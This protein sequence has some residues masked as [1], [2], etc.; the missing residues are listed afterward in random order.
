MPHV[1]TAQVDQ[2]VT[3]IKT[4]ETVTVDSREELATARPVIE[5]SNQ[6][7]ILVGSADTK[8]LLTNVSSALAAAQLS[9]EEVTA[10]KVEEGS[11]VRLRVNDHARALKI[12]NQTWDIGRNYGQSQ[13]FGTEAAADILSQVEYQAVSGDALLV[14]LEDKPG[15]LASIMKR[16]RD[17]NI[18][19]RSVRLLWRGKYKAVVELA[20]P[21]PV[22][23]KSL[24]TDQVF[25]H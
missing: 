22:R 25:I 7:I 11:V 16:C 20:S 21:E 4:A 6:E 12:L 13:P 2:L 19:I 10:V 18:P 3:D 14:Q 17:Q 23:L 8:N 24:L 5:G 9:I 1:T 15:S